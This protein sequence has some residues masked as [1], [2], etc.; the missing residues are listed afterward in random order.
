M[1]YLLILTSVV[2][3]PVVV[4]DSGGDLGDV[5]VATGD[6]VTSVGTVPEVS[7]NVGYTGMWSTAAS[8]DNETLTV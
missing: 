7:N 6:G 8:N 3:G 4:C 5:T 1:G 2:S